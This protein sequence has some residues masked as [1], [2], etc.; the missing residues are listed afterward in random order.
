MANHLRRQ[1]SFSYD[2]LSKLLIHVSKR[3]Y[4]KYQRGCNRGNRD[5]P[6]KFSAKSQRDQSAK[7]KAKDQPK[8]AKKSKKQKRSDAPEQDY[9][10]FLLFFGWVGF[11]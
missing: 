11:K 4:R 5:Q 8:Q 3:Q 9:K 6:L 2:V 10:R 1:A 7:N